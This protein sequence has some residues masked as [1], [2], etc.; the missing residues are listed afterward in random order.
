M[1]I[2]KEEEN[3]LRKERRQRAEYMKDIGMAG[4]RYYSDYISRA[5]FEESSALF[6]KEQWEQEIEIRNCIEH[7]KPEY[8]DIIIDTYYIGTPANEIAVRDGITEPAISKRKTRALESLRKML[9]VE[10][11]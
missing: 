4:K 1:E 6:R 2:K 7:L 3:L 9:S 10:L 5:N 11:T 8:R